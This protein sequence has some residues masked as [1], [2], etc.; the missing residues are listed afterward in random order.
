MRHS[1]PP[2]MRLTQRVAGGYQA[3]IQ[4]E[5]SGALFVSSWSY[6]RMTEVMTTVGERLRQARVELGLSHREVA[7]TTKIQATLLQYIEEDRFEEFPAEVFARGF[8]RNYAKELR[9]DE[10]EVLEQYLAQ[11]RQQLRTLRNSVELAAEPVTKSVERQDGRFADRSAFGR[12][13]YGAGVAALVIALALAVLM[14]GGKDDVSQTAS[15]QQGDTEQSETW[16]PAPEGQNDWRT[17]R[18]N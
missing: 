1:Y 11:T 12:A 15:F 9:L 7:A 6:E 10:D 2:G 17:V 13:A 5:R 16:R 8:V 14:F 3:R 18:E 4:I